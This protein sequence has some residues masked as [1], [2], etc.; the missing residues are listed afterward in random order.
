MRQLD[1]GRRSSRGGQACTLSFLLSCSH[2]HTQLHNPESSGKEPPKTFTFDQVYDWNSRQDTI[3][4][5]TAKPIV[6]AC[7]DGYNGEKLCAP[8]RRSRQAGKQ[9]RAQEG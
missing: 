9:E 6:D 8:H 3:F 7:M 1:R 4:E 2:P 5:I